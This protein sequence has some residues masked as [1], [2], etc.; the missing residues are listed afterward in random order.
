MTPRQTQI[1][2]LRIDAWAH[3]CLWVWIGWIMVR[4]GMDGSIFWTVFMA[5]IGAWQMTTWRIII[6]ELRTAKK[7]R[8][9]DG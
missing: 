7:K 8:P 2:R 4:N 3:G 5:G 6:N 1:R 9:P